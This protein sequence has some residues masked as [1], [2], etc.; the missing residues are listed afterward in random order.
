MEY[1]NFETE[2]KLHKAY[3]EHWAHILP[4]VPEQHRARFLKVI[5]QG[6]AMPVALDLVLVSAKMSEDEFNYRLSDLVKG[7]N[8]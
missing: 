8:D 1:K 3:S 6:V 7:M 2:A 4:G 5:A